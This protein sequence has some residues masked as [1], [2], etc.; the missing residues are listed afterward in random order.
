M[1]EGQ[2]DTMVKLREML[3]QSQLGQLQVREGCRRREWR[4]LGC[5]VL[6][7]APGLVIV[8]MTMVLPFSELRGRGPSSAT[9][10]PA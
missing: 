6:S 4:P 1:I 3:H 8:V 5:T 10:G 7:A 9:G 2:N